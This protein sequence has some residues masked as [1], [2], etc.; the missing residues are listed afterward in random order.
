[1]KYKMFIDDE[2]WPAAP[3]WL[4]CRSSRDCILAV[5][6]YG[7]P[8][9]IAFD[10]DLGGDDTSMAFIKWLDLRLGDGTLK[11]PENFK[12]S[13]HSQNPVG[14]KNIELYM[15]DLIQYY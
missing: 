2:R 4:I 7:L 11:L 1:M 3:D 12:F 14:A 8:E 9:F 5:E 15:N 13:V 6:Y 10:H